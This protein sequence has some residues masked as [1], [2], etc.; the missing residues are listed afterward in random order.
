MRI[1]A[2]K[3]RGLVLKTFDFDNVRPTL[4][5][6]REAIFNK[7]QF[8]IMDC[9][10]LDLFCG[11]GAVSLE[12]LSRGA[13]KVVSVDNNKNSISI[14][15][16]NFKKAKESLNLIND[17]YVTAL[18]SIK[19]SF[20]FIFID[21]PYLTD[22]AEIAMKLIVENKTLKDSGLIIYEHLSDKQFLI[23]HQLEVVDSKKYGTVV[24]TYIRWKND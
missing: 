5:R 13:G 7:I 11:T 10:V 8:D 1:V 3:H 14:I 16:E 15:K 18:K 22:Y 9:C 17:D 21:P 12:F 6:V 4:D 2:G 23:P 24:V 20:D 19:E